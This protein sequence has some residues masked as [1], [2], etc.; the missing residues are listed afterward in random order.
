MH[1]RHFL[2][3]LLAASLCALAVVASLH[4]RINPVWLIALGAAAGVI[5]G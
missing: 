4:G 5:W 2:H 1:R 3:S